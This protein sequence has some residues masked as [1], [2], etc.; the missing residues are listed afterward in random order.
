MEQLPLFT[1]LNPGESTTVEICRQ[2][3]RQ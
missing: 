2:G 1:E 3:P